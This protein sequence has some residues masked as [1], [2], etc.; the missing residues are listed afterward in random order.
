[1]Q[2]IDF[3]KSCG[4]VCTGLLLPYVFQ[5][6]QT[7]YYY[8][9]HALELNQITLLKS[10]FMTEGKQDKGYRK[11]VLL[12]TEKFNFP[13]CVY[14]L[15]DSSYSALLLECTHKSCELK[16]EGNYL[17]CPCHGSEFSNKGEV[18][19]PPAEENLKIF[20]ISENEQTLVIHL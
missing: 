9:K 5:G 3:I 8:A 1:M 16:P 19:N 11:F 7:P 4:L 14:K 13:I 10:E 17:I 20:K 15:A 12:K 18:L 6:C 2:R